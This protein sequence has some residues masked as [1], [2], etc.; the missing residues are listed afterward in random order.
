[1]QVYRLAYMASVRTPNAQIDNQ[2]KEFERT[3]ANVTQSDA[4]H[5]LIPSQNAA[6]LRFDP[7]DA[8]DW[9]G[10]QHQAFFATLRAAD[11]NRPV[12]FCRQYRAVFTGDGKRQESSRVKA[13][14]KKAE[15]T[16]NTVSSFKREDR[17]RP[18][19]DPENKRIK[20]AGRLI[21]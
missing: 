17:L 5:P 7:I 9:L 19:E 13:I 21:R 4:I 6:G 10:I 12:P 3:L 16:H 8:V 15:P 2:I 11:P 1:M 18:S 20:H 14:D